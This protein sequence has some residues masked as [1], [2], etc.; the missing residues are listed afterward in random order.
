LQLLRQTKSPPWS[1]LRVCLL[2]LL[3]VPLHP[4]R[5]LLLLVLLRRCSHPSCLLLLQE[6][7][8]RCPSCQQEQALL[9]SWQQALQQ[10]EHPNC[11]LLCWV[12]PSCRRQLPPV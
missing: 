1:W 5:H 9:V 6:Q 7:V 4:S 8:Q 11:L 12:H 10:Q 2:L 3:L